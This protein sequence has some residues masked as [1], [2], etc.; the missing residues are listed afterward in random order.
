MRTGRRD[1]AQLQ[2]NFHSLERYVVETRVVGWQSRSSEKGLD[3]GGRVLDRSDDLLECVHAGSAVSLTER[4]NKALKQVDTRAVLRCVRAVR[5]ALASCADFANHGLGRQV[6]DRA[7]LV[8]VR[9]LVFLALLVKVVQ[10]N[11]LGCQRRTAVPQ[12]VVVGRRQSRVDAR[13]RSFEIFQ[14]FVQF[15]V[16]VGQA[17]FVGFSG[18]QQSA[19]FDQTFLQL[20]ERFEFEV[21]Q[22]VGLLHGQAVK[23]E[24]LGSRHLGVGLHERD[25]QQGGDDEE[26]ACAGHCEV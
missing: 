4:V 14:R 20:A 19:E 9:P 26:D 10:L 13:A 18:R 15:G 8:I 5:D 22:V 25:R 21:R 24:R 1:K 3:L 11:L 23:L 7:T 6:F 12:G 2:L 16:T 17:H